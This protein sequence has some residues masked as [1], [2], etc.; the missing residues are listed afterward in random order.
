MVRLRK[1]V[2]NWTFPVIIVFGIVKLLQLLR[3]L[4]CNPKVDG[5]RKTTQVYLRT[6]E[7]KFVLTAFRLKLPTGISCQMVN[8][9]EDRKVLVIKGLI[10]FFR[11]EPLTHCKVEWGMFFARK[12]SKKEIDIVH[13]LFDDHGRLL[14]IIPYFS[15]L[16]TD[17]ANNNLCNSVIKEI[18]RVFREAYNDT[19]DIS[20]K[21]RPL[22]L[23]RELSSRIRKG[24]K[25]YPKNFTRQAQL[26][27]DRILS[28]TF[29]I[30]ERILPL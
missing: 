3:K 10:D 13:S 26:Y 25:K 9:Q 4:G 1:L 20:D 28:S 12:I 11:N 22:I 2:N 19:K 27:L 29:I 6:E 21:R 24:Y 23:K 15:P 18:T 5:W 8:E 7:S 17:E 16:F 30:F 14:E